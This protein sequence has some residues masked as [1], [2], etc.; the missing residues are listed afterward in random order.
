MVDRAACGSARRGGGRSGGRLRADAGGPELEERVDDLRVELAAALRGD[1][2][3]RVGLRPRVL[4]RARGD[5]RVVDVADRADAPG[6]RDLLAAQAG[7]VA[8]AV[9][10]LVM[11]ARDRLGD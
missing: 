2:G 8:A 9:P 1:L 6:E 10:A 3:E 7:R 4:V 5:E 11:R